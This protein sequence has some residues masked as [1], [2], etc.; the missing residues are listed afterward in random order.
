M[1]KLMNK[2]LIAAAVLSVFG[3]SSALAASAS[4]NIQV[5]ATVNPSCVVSATNVAFG[6]FT[7]AAT[8]NASATGG[9]SSTCTKTTAYNITID[10]GASGSIANRAMAGATQGNADKLSYNLFLDAGHSS[11]WGDGTTGGKLSAVG[12]GAAQAATV[13]AKLPLNQYLTPDS[14][15]DTLTVTLAY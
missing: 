7:P 4:S 12:N 6:T 15:A 3:V 8:G 11:I 10:G 1:K 13:Y 2:K 9:I 14:Y 5:N